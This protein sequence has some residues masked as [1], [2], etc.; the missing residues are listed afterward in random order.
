MY[1]VYFSIEHFY[2]AADEFNEYAE[3]IRKLRFLAR[4]ES[5]DNQDNILKQRFEKKFHEPRKHGKFLYIMNLLNYNLIHIIK[6][7]VE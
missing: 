5:I 2:F 1:E 3:L 7:D 6:E 4:H